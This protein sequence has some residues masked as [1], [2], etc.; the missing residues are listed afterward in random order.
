M[1]LQNH[2]VFQAGRALR[3]SPVQNP[4]QSRVSSEI[5]WGC[6]KALS[7]LVLK[8]LQEWNYNETM[9]NDGFNKWAKFNGAVCKDIRLW[10]VDERCRCTGGN[11][12][13]RG[14]GWHFMKVKSHWILHK[15]NHRLCQPRNTRENRQTLPPLNGLQLRSH[16]EHWVWWPACAARIKPKTLLM[17]AA[18]P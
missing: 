11:D 4:T 2:M 5:R 14:H 16:L 3:L 9:Q 7:K 8:N 15:H 17:Q 10:P 12:H 13:F 18:D 1:E 6:L